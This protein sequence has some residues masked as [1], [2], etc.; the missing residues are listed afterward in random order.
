M[1]IVVLDIVGLSPELLELKSIIPNISSLIKKNG[2][3][4][5]KPSFPSVTCTVQ[6]SLTTGQPPSKH[7]I[8]SNGIY[9]RQTREVNFWGRYNAVLESDRIWNLIKKE[10]SDFSSLAF[11][12]LNSVYCNA[13]Y[14]MVPAPFHTHDGGMIQ[15]CYSKPSNLYSETC[16]YLGKTFNLMSF[17]G[18]M[19]SFD[20]S[21]WIFDAGMY[22]LRK[23]NP[24]LSFIYIPH[25][26]YASQKFGPKSEQVKDELKK[27]DG[28]VGE[29]I[30]YQKKK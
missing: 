1:P 25:L 27:V 24:S 4:S 20:S 29:L 15:W 21:R 19:A 2:M 9:D 12:L 18:P 5:M 16:S 26:D 17:W 14:T 7:G 8:I 11:F 22:S 28:L 6:A 10:S 30:E 13:D 23:Y 3:L